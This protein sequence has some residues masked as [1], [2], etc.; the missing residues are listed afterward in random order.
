MAVDY[1][2]EH[3][4]TVGHLLSLPF[5]RVSMRDMEAVL[6]S[7]GT[8]ESHACIECQRVII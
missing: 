5:D 4:L 1:H 7:L 8:A 6:Q 3:K 2:Y